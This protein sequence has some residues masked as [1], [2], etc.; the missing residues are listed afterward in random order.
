MK[1]SQYIQYV[2]NKSNNSGNNL[3]K[4]KQII[5]TIVAFYSIVLFYR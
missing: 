3:L 4:F 5:T 1:K 2:C